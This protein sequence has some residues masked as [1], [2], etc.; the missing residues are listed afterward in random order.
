MNERSSF[1]NSESQEKEPNPW[2]KAILAEREHYKDEHI[3]RLRPVIDRLPEKNSFLILGDACKKT[4]YDFLHSEGFKHGVNVDQSELIH[5]NEVLRNDDQ[6]I[7]LICDTFE[8][9]D[10]PPEKFD[11]IYGKSIAFVSKEDMPLLFAKLFDHLQ[12]HGSFVGVFGMEND[13]IRK[14][15]W[16][17]EEIRNL[18]KSTGF[19][20]VNVVEY[21][22]E[23][24][25]LLQKPS[26]FHTCI[27]LARK[28]K[29]ATQV[30]Q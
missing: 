11:F 28:Q 22:K 8:D 6:R 26:Q 1:G 17:M 3:K 5:D 9:A 14:I 15:W 16:T 30:T 20:I 13:S 18:A 19:N 10:L 23:G 4:S 24:E 25:S 7:Q 21:N 29:D 2:D 27:F 12:D